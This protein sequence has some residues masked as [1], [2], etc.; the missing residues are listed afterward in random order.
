MQ[1]FIRPDDS[2]LTPT[3]IDGFEADFTVINACEI[4]NENWEERGLN[5]EVFVAL[6]V[7]QG[8]GDTHRGQWV[9]FWLTACADDRRNGCRHAARL[10]SAYCRDGSGWACNEYGVL[11][12]P[13][14]RPFYCHTDKKNAK[15]RNQ[16]NEKK[17]RRETS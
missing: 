11:I 2:A 12:Q 7:A 16:G 10:T 6:S 3:G 13:A 5:S 9:T 1:M 17:M 8:V 15:Q 14:L 4:V